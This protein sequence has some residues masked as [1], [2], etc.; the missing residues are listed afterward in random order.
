MKAWEDEII[1]EKVNS[2]KDVPGQSFD[3]EA[4]WDKLQIRLE[5][6]AMRQHSRRFYWAAAILLLL[7]GL[8]FLAHQP[9]KTIQ[10][11]KPGTANIYR[12]LSAAPQPRITSKAHTKA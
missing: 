2:L 11:E 12:S 8:P 10:I 7:T 5:K 4:A 6:P 1:R 9:G 3:G